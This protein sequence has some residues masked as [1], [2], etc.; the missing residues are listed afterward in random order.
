MLS[1]LISTFVQ[2]NAFLESVVEEDGGEEEGVFQ[3]RPNRFKIRIKI[4]SVDMIVIM[5]QKQQPVIVNLIATI[6]GVKVIRKGNT[7]SF[8][9]EGEGYRPCV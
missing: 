9:T 7:C 6:K 4:P 3:I 1:P 8:Y 5:I 2:N